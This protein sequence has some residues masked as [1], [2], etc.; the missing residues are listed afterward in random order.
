M[1]AHRTGTP[2]VAGGHGIPFL[3]GFHRGHACC[4]GSHRMGSQR[5][6]RLGRE[7][8][9]PL[10]ESFPITLVLSLCLGVGG[11]G[12]AGSTPSFEAASEATAVA[13]S[14]GGDTAVN[15]TV[16]AGGA[17]SS[18]TDST[19][20]NSGSSGGTG[21]ASASASGVQVGGVGSGSGGF[22]PVTSTTGAGGGPACP[23]V[24]PRADVP[25]ET[26]R[27]PD[28]CDFGATC[29]PEPISGC[30][31]CI[32][33]QRA[34]EADEQCGEAERCV[35]FESL[36]T[37]LCAFGLASECRPACTATSCGDGYECIDGACSP[38]SCENGYECDAGLVC[39]S[40]RPTSDAHGCAQPNCHE[41][42]QCEAGTACDAG[43]GE[44]RVVHCS[45][46]GTAACPVNTQCEP[47]ALGRGC[48]PK[49]C[50]V[51]DD[52]DCGVCIQ[53]CSG[54]SCPRGQCANRLYVCQHPVP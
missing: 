34:C 17:A 46:G 52:C 5:T 15:G 26:C 42:R 23:G 13:S 33:P 40:G 30:G 4:F 54:D 2:P 18:A 37:C 27:S 7:L 47:E 14:A 3:G 32:E 49:P 45:E 1:L 43:T 24:E 28:D 51:D 41:G 8:A 6:F 48:V 9:T 36:E 38:R 29:S 19:A 10:P 31:F 25:G 39:A 53:S 11:C 21:G 12:S 16:A 22:G 35:E 50:D 20:T 44:C